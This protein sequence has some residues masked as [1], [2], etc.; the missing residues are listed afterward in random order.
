MKGIYVAG[1]LV[2]AGGL[3]V[4]IGTHRTS[5]AEP[6]SSAGTKT[7][8]SPSQLRRQ[9]IV[10]LCFLE[11][12]PRGSREKGT[13]ELLA[14]PRLMTED[15][16]QCSFLAGRERFVDDQPAGAVCIK[17]GAQFSMIPTLGKGKNRG[18][19][20]LDATLQVEKLQD[21]PG[22]KVCL[23]GRNVRSLGW[24]RLGEVVTLRVT[25]EASGKQ[26]WAEVVVEEQ[27]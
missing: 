9:V 4:A 17:E 15:G 10:N 25:D 24:V 2:A 13:L 18:K 22:N 3:T 12:D 8:S 7:A 6:V 20:F 1:L 19:V 23:R 11:G 27:K 21:E 5:A 14:E 16:R 26:T